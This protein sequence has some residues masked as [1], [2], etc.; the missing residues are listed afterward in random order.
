[1]LVFDERGNRSTRRKPLVAEWR[2]NKLNP[3]MTSDPG[4]KPRPHWWKASALTTAPT[5][6][7]KNFPCRK[8]WE[9]IWLW[10]KHLITHIL[11][12][13]IGN[14]WFELL[15]YLNSSFFNKLIYYT[16]L[17]ELTGKNNI[18]YHYLLLIIIF[19]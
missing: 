13:E 2:T 11:I 6:H 17:R 19:E 1:M 10:T 12:W 8:A 16:W 14:L 9:I 3:H 7:P 5:L 18:V 4:I 15:G